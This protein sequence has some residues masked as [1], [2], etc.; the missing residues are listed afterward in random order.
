MP[1]LAAPLA[2]GTGPQLHLER[3]DRM[4]DVENALPWLQLKRL[5]WQISTT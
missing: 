2:I 4:R 5:I 1:N 3:D